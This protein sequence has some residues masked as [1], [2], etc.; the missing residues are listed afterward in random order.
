MKLLTTSQIHFAFFRLV[1]CQKLISNLNKYGGKTVTSVFHMKLVDFNEMIYFYSLVCVRVLWSV[2]SW[3]WAPVLFSDSFSAPH[4]SFGADRF[5][6]LPPPFC[7][8]W[9]EFWALVLVSF[10]SLDL[11]AG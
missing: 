7:F 4:A 9:G 6:R 3:I 8:G 2:K 11:I 5:F 1:V 10:S